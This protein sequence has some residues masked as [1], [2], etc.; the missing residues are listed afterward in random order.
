MRPL[1][2]PRLLSFRRIRLSPR[3]TTTPRAHHR[4]N[5]SVRGLQW[6][7]GCLGRCDR[8]LPTGTGRPDGRLDLPAGSTAGGDASRRRCEEA[9]LR[10]GT[11]D[12]FS[13]R[14]RSRIC[15]G[16]S[17][18]SSLPSRIWP[19]WV[20]KPFRPSATRANTYSALDPLK[21]EIGSEACA[22]SSE[23]LAT[24]AIASATPFSADNAMRT[25]SRSRDNSRRCCAGSLAIRSRISTTI[26]RWPRSF[27][28][29]FI[30]V[31]SAVP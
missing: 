27:T 23:C 16:V 6:S 7:L 24:I 26:L 20:R 31:L 29:L 14:S 9:L 21:K 1:V 8:G 12:P 30:R 4:S 18:G 28:P 15:S 13:N 19:W 22:H 17:S 25:N 5:G 10:R 2:V 11:A 3:A